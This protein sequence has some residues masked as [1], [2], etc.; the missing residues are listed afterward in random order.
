MRL[1]ICAFLLALVAMTFSSGP[2]SAEKVRCSAIRDSAMC[3]GESIC[4]YD[5]NGQ[6]CLE[7]T[8]PAEDACAVHDGEGTC[9][10]SS[11]GCAWNSDDKKCATKAN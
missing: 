1:M 3:V 10:S 8:R 11:F 5:V 9:D 7:G 4:W 2:A 6:G